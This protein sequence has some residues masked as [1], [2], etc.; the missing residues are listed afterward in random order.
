MK[1]LLINEK[2]SEAYSELRHPWTFWPKLFSRFV[3]LASEYTSEDGYKQQTYYGLPKIHAIFQTKCALCNATIIAGVVS[4]IFQRIIF[5]EVPVIHYQASHLKMLAMI[6]NHDKNA[7][8]VE[9]ASC[10][11]SKKESN[12]RK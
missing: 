12:K 6:F 10:L 1:L 4:D 9:T 8:I 3:R 11:F 5:L 7:N 2:G